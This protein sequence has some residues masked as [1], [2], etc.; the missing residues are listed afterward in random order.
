MGVPILGYLFDIFYSPRW[1]KGL[2]THGAEV[3]SISNLHIRLHELPSFTYSVD[4]DID[5]LRHVSLVG[6]LGHVHHCFTP[7]VVLFSFLIFI[8]Y[9][10]I[11]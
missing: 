8:R 3:I 10:V 1:T 2:E 6:F 5:I 4:I 9:R 11:W 7:A